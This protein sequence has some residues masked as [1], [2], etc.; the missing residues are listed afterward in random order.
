MDNYIQRLT[1]M[2]KSHPKCLERAS[3]LH[4]LLCDMFPKEKLKNK[5]LMDAYQ[6][7][8][9]AE[10]S[11]GGKPDVNALNRMLDKLTV[12]AGITEDNAY[13][14][15]DTWLIVLGKKAHKI[16]RKNPEEYDRKPQR[17]DIQLVDGKQTSEL[18]PLRKIL[19]KLSEAYLAGKLKGNMPTD[20]LDYGD[21]FRTDPTKSSG[22]SPRVI[23]EDPVLRMNAMGSFSAQRTGVPCGEYSYDI[24]SI[25]QRIAPNMPITQGNIY[26][27]LQ[28]N[29]LAQELLGDLDPNNIKIV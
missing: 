8:V 6:I 2:I 12:D 18:S 23:Y 13:W 9:T 11:K 10:L 14:A 25:I 17:N 16:N 20:Y 3:T 22:H 1:E 29:P 4:G 19:V 7:G 24:T 28:N 15:I 27:L 21:I 26:D 5:L